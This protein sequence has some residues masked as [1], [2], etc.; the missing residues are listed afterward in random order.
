GLFMSQPP[1]REWNGFWTTN[2]G[3]VK[4]MTNYIRHDIYSNKLIYRFEE[5]IKIEY[6]DQLQTL[7]NLE[8]D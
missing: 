3:V 6:G 1:G 4:L 7:L 2:P 8:M 5:A